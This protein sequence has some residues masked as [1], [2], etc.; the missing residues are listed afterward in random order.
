MNVA[1]YKKLVVAAVVITMSGML[2]GLAPSVGQEAKKTDKTEKKAK[3]RLPAY[4]ADIVTE[5]QRDK[6]YAIQAKHQAKIEELN[7]ALTAANKARDA[8]IESVLTPEQKIKLKA[9]KDEAA[10]KKKKNAADKKAAE[11][12]KK[13]APAAEAKTTAKPKAP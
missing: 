1:L 8:E 12:G 9:A 4:Y 5:E 6:I 13:A 7:A 10:A 3:G 2:A 11:E